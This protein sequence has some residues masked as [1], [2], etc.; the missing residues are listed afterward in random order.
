[1]D[2][3]LPVYKLAKILVSRY[4]NCFKFIGLFQHGL[5]WNAWR[6]FGNVQHLMPI[7]PKS[8]NNLPIDAF[9]GQKVHCT[10][11]GMG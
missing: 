9:I 3:T 2:S 11:S 6:H 1:M 8:L 5:V 10:D 7:L 4:E